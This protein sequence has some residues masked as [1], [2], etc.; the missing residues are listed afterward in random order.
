MNKTKCHAEKF[1]LIEL[2]VVIA[3]I[4]I[5]AGMLL[6]ALN[7]ARER[8]RSI[9]CLSNIKNL[10]TFLTLYADDNNG[11]VAT[12][13][14]TGTNTW[15]DWPIMLIYNSK[16]DVY[17][18]EAASKSKY[19]RCPSVQTAADVDSD[20][21]GAFVAYGVFSKARDDNNCSIPKKYGL[22]SKN[23][24]Y[25]AV[26]LKGIAEPSRYQFFMD[27]IGSYNG[28]WRQGARA[29]I[30][31]ETI[32]DNQLSTS[33]HIHMRHSKA[34][35]VGFADGHAAPQTPANMIDNFNIMYEGSANKPATFYY[36][37]NDYIIKSLAL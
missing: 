17:D 1:T 31:S 2:L 26:K 23:A 20:A 28:I 25:Y 22:G 37:E 21:K 32:A 18:T 30:N 36:R 15:R 13:M 8:A 27:N 35:N 24:G 10:G 11:I 4:A 34:A 16:P 7:K 9:S 29:H 33:G 12:L 5:L 14:T 6:P 3:I 19:T